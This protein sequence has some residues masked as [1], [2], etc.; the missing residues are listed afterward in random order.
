MNCILSDTEIENDGKESVKY[1][2][3]Q[4]HSNLISFLILIETLAIIA[5]RTILDSKTFEKAK[6]VWIKLIEQAE[7]KFGDKTIPTH[8]SFSEYFLEHF[9]ERF[10]NEIPSSEHLVDD[11][12][13]F[14]GKGEIIEN[15][16]L[17][18]AD[19]SLAGIQ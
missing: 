17:S 18:L 7:S 19:L 4:N 16:C 11:F 10:L 12:F 5:D 8:Y 13:D 2:S 9:K 3:K 15:G 6:D 14:F 1:E